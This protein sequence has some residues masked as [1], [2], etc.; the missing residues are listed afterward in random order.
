MN[1]ITDVEGLESCAYESA[2]DTCTLEELSC[3]VTVVVGGQE[4]E[5]ACDEIAAQFGAEICSEESETD[6]DCSTFFVVDGLEYCYYD[7]AYDTCSGN[8]TYC[9]ASLGINGEYFTCDC[10]GEESEC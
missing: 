2:Y 6:K 1:L 10:L 7:T 4:Y 8:E 5:G 3:N 9:N